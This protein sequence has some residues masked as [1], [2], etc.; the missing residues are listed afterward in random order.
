MAL[1]LFFRIVV[2]PLRTSPFPAR[3]E[4]SGINI[5]ILR[6]LV[7]LRVVFHIHSGGDQIVRRDGRERICGGRNQFDA[8]L[9]RLG[10]EYL[11]LGSHGAP[12]FVAGLFCKLPCRRSTNSNV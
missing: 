5:E 9:E 4:L 11:P 3:G 6:Q 7:N 10:L 12:I 1:P 8:R 2:G